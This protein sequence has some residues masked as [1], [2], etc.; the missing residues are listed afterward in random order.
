MRLTVGLDGVVRA[1]LI[2]GVAGGEPGVGKA[3]SLQ[4][5]RPGD[6]ADFD[7]IVWQGQAR[8]ADLTDFARSPQGDGPRR[9]LH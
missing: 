8:T 3:R 9:V 6:E 2:D 5:R 4:R 1:H 7:L